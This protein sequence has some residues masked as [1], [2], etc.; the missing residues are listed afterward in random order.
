MEAVSVRFISRAETVPLRRARLNPD[1]T[2]EEAERNAQGH[3]DAFQCGTFIGGT[4]LSVVTFHPEAVP[5]HPGGLSPPPF[6]H[7]WRL[8]ALATAAWQEGKGLARLAIGF[9]LRH[10]FSTAPPGST[11]VWLYGRAA[12]Y[13][14]YDRLGF[15]RAGL[16]F[17]TDT[18]PHDL[19]WICGPLA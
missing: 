9:G 5:S 3:T 18:R 2:P 15:S 7:P 17:T 19:F 4:L 8:R 12:A 14:F 10:L 16:T 6:S 13:G 11:G 1:L